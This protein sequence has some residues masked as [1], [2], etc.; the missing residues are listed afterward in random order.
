MPLTRFFLRRPPVPGLPPPALPWRW[1]QG[2]QPLARAPLQDRRLFAAPACAGRFEPDGAEQSLLRQHFAQARARFPGPGYLEWLQFF[3]QFAAPASY[4]EIGVETG[5][6]FAF[7]QA[8]TLAVGVDPQLDIQYALRARSKLFQLTSG[9]FFAQPDLDAVFEGRGIELA[10]IDGLH[11]FDQ[12]L[13]D[14]RHIE[15]HAQRHTIVLFH[16]T[17]PLAPLTAS[18]QRESIFWCGDTWKAIVLLQRHRPDLQVFTLPTYPSG[19]TVVTRLD[20]HS[21]LLGAR[22]DALC[23]EAM[24]WRFEDFQGE[25]GR[26]LNEIPNEAE[27]VVRRLSG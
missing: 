24:H 10:F 26:H 8:P 5:A 18:R 2:P 6:S 17:F 7:A 9:A 19:L 4:L 25:L 1:L 21:R 20:P 11:T 22:F 3:Q 13:I 15:Q 12:A 16:D 23:E 14:F 27:Q